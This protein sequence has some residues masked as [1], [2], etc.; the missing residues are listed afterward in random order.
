QSP[1]NGVIAPYN[2]TV[3]LLIGGTST[4]A[5]KFAFI[6]NASGTPTATISGNLSLKVPTG[7]APANT[8]NLLNNGTFGIYNSVGGDAGLGANPALFVASSGNVGVGTT[9]PSEKLQLAG[10][11]I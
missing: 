10:G 5:A 4:A 11:N 9:T 3:D 8:L 7:N 1:S 2:N 6:N